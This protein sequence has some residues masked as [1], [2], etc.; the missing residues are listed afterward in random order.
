MKQ[1]KILLI[2]DD[3]SLLEVTA[4]HLEQ[5]GYAVTCATT[6]E[7]GLLKFKEDNYE[8]V[9]TDLAL[10]KMN[11]IEVLKEVKHLSRDVVVIIITAFGTVENA[12]EACLLGAEDYLTK[13]FSREQLRFALGKALRLRR[14]Q[15]ENVQLKGQ[16][17]DRGKRK[18]FHLW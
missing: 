2:D 11:G 4:H 12:V 3:E 8:A 1:N 9:L 18:R 5:T 7:E 10:P 13:P 14:L 16:L 17:L 15:A 6:G